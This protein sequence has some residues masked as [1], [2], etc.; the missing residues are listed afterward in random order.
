MALPAIASAGGV[1]AA[2]GA[3]RALACAA[4]GFTA[5]GATGLGAGFLAIGRIGCGTATGGGPAIGGGAGSAGIGIG[6][7]ST[8]F[9]TAPPRPACARYIRVR[10]C[11][12]S[13]RSCSMYSLVVTPTRIVAIEPPVT[14][15]ASELVA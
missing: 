8:P 5:A 4:G 12:C 10:I 13:L 1:A 2:A 7:R 9:M 3:G 15:T 6:A 11:A 14:V